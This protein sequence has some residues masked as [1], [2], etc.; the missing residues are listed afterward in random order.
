MDE[1]FPHARLCQLFQ[2]LARLAQSQAAQHHRADVKLPPDQVIQRHAA[3]QQV[4]TRLAGRQGDLVL[5]L[6]AFQRLD[7]NQGHFTVGCVGLEERALPLA[8]T[9]A[10]Q[11]LAGDR[12]RL[13]D[14]LGVALCFGGDEDRFE[15]TL[16]HD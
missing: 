3:H 4:A 7:F 6:Q 15:L 5:A 14:P 1:A 10:D 16:N 11:P 8:V 12:L 13:V 2:V 9:V